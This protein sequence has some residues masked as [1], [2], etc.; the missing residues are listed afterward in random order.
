MG[1]LDCPKETE[2][3]SPVSFLKTTR[4][5][6]RNPL[7]TFASGRTDS[8][9]I[10]VSL[11]ARTATNSISSNAG[12]S[13]HS[14]SEKDCCR[15]RWSHRRR[16]LHRAQKN[17]TSRKNPFRSREAG[18]DCFPGGLASWNRGGMEGVG[19]AA[20]AERSRRLSRRL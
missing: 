11:V 15:Y 19:R 2:S 5:A 17:Q 18:T 10:I 13:R 3:T 16:N 12:R 14:R 20:K 7:A 8:P 9:G 4:E 6:T 1:T